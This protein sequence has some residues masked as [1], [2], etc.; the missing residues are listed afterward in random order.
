MALFCFFS[1]RQFSEVLDVKALQESL[2]WFIISL[3]PIC[4]LG[5]YLESFSSDLQYLPRF[6]VPKTCPDL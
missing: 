3:D 2:P 1:R 5:P 4:N 6:V